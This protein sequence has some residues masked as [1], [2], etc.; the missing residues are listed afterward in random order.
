[1]H[2]CT[3]PLQVQAPLSPE[4][5]AAHTPKLSRLLADGWGET[6][7]KIC[8]GAAGLVRDELSKRLGGG[9][10][11]SQLSL[12]CA[13]K[14]SRNVA[15]LRCAPPCNA[16][17][18]QTALQRGLGGQWECSHWVVRCAFMRKCSY[19]L[20][21]IVP[22]TH[23]F[24]FLCKSTHSPNPCSLHFNLVRASCTGGAGCRG[25]HV[26]NIS[27]VSPRAY[28]HRMQRRPW[29][30]LHAHQRAVGQRALVG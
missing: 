8:D 28:S 17:H 12:G 4:A 10:W 2:L 26:Q 29:R 16:Y 18:A 1:M 22:C 14:A 5:W 27:P 7:V 3:R 21:A 13:L 25:R 30:R 11:R 15:E 24:G 20:V 6:L 19:L 9:L 23:V